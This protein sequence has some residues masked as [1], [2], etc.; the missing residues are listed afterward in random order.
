MNLGLLTP[1][2]L[3]ISRS[4]KH[5]LMKGASIGYHVL[6]DQLIMYIF[7]FGVFENGKGKCE[8]ELPRTWLPTRETD[9]DATQ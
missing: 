3:Y 4:T 7:L 9:R 2:L 1:N 8:K 5:E 6:L